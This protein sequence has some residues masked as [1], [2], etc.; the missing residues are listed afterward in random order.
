MAEELQSLIEKIN[1]DGVEKATAEADRIIAEAK[2]KAA[3]TVSKAKEESAAFA[4]D[5]DR[6]AKE[7]AERSKE[8]IKQ[9]ARDAVIAVERSVTRLLES[10]LRSN[11]DAALSDPAAAAAIAGS[12]VKDIVGAGEVSAGAKIIESLRAQLA[13]KQ[14]FTVLLDETLGTGF[15]VKVDGG[16]VE[17]DFTGA[18]VA[19][20]LA[21]RLR[22]DLAKIMAEA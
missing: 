13:S 12:A 14:N 16:R 9:A 2:E 1:R 10:I 15:T 22:P 21:K 17:H 8:T 19:A 11:V 3:A 20:E 5:A 6:K 18:T 4:A 7:A